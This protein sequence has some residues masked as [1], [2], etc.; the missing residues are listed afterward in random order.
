MTAATTDVPAARSGLRAVAL[1]SEH[2]GWGLTLEPGLLGLLV[3]PS[4]AGLA[5]AL[6]AL[7]AFLARTPLKL[8]LVDR[9][10]GRALERTTLAR[11]VA[12]LELVV[13]VGL[14]ATAVVT[15]TSAF[16]APLAVAAPLIAVEAW[17]D[18]R[19]RSRRLVPEVAG[20]VAVCS[21]TPMIVL[22]D[23]EAG[24]LAVG[25]WLVLAARVVTAIPHVRD[26]IAELHGREVRAVTTVVADGLA[27]AL[28]ALA[29]GLDAQLVA[30]ALAVVAVVVIQR[31]S[32]RHPTSRAVVL[33]IRQM[34]LGFGLVV[35]T[36]LGVILA[37]G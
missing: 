8:A 9:R 26:R 13:L 29:V 22:A 20:A 6:A 10:R 36:A 11:R 23:G 1:P 21:V 37:S 14:V 33:G 2:G 7:V 18:L 16:W 31:V 30:G 5:L 17:F 15:A 27:L 25:L 4:V 12:A 32:A 34:A 3:S 24:A 28:A 35:V 19:S